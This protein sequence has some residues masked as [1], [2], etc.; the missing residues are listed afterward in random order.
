MWENTDQKNSEYEHFLHTSVLYKM[1]KQLK[2]TNS[3]KFKDAQTLR[4]AILV[5]S[6]H[7]INKMHIT[8]HPWNFMLF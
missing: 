1:I 8:N 6:K 2:M 7:N 3:N 5:I 4:D